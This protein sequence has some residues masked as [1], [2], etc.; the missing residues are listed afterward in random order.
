MRFQFGFRSEEG[1]ENMK[2]FVIANTVVLLTTMT[3]PHIQTLFGM[4]TDALYGA[5]GVL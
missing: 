3:Y 1:V 5:D 2:L 4:I